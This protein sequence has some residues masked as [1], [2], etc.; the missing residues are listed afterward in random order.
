MRRATVVMAVALFVPVLLLGLG[1]SGQ[2]A[3]PPMTPKKPVTTEYQGVKVTDNYQWL[4]N[5][6]DPAVQKWISEENQYSRTFLDRIPERKDIYSYLEKIYGKESKD[7][8]SLQYQGGMIFAKKSQPPLEQPLLV[9]LASADDTTAERV[10]LDVNKL[11]T[12]GHTA[13]DFYTPSLDGKMIAVSLSEGGSEEGTVYVYDVATGQATSDTVPR[14]NGPTAGG[15]VAWNA[16]GTGFYYTHYPRFGERPEEDLSFYQQV[17]FH[18]LGTPSDSDSYVIG[19]EFPRIAEI[20]LE[21]S[22]DGKYILAVVANGDGGEY[23]HYLLSPNGK[24]TQITQFDDKVTTAMFGPDQ[25]LY[26]MSLDQAPHGKIIRVPLSRPQLISATVVVPTGEPVIK[27]FV[28]ARHVVYVA[29]LLG[30]PMQ[31]RVFDH[32]GNM[33]GN[34]KIE[35]VS[36]VSKMLSIGDDKILFNNT[37]YTVPPAWFEYEPD[38]KEPIRTQLFQTSPADFSNV[39]VVREFATAED[40]TKIPM[41]ILQP[42]GTRRDGENPTVLYGYGAYG[43]SE[44]PYFDPATSVWL[45]NGGVYV[46]ANIRGGGEYGEEWH[47]AGNLANKQTTFSDFATVAEWLITARYTSRE[48]LAIEGGSAGGLLMGVV[49]TQHPDLIRAVVSYVGVYDALRSEFEPNGEFN[50]T[51]FGSVKNAE[52]FKALY[53]YSPYHHVVDSVPYPAVLMLTG[54][55]DQR[56]SPANSFKMT[57]RLQEATSSGDPILLRTSYNAGHG[58]GSSLSQKINQESDV[59][60]FLFDELGLRYRPM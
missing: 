34:V 25:A 4:E 38:F 39:E 1:C 24:W 18:K 13:I 8:Y 44:T 53:A 49:L 16:D 31:V 56:V 23:S 7:Y 12:T 41:S 36:S 28:P 40:G 55:N 50:I 14:V 30:G 26:M 5:I 42:K 46:Y 57:A 59:W 19:K 60:A 11:D 22:P 6:N 58:I 33:K 32:D 17:Y 52:Q 48:K 45:D 3:K 37:S 35:T 9:T 2:S 51:E 27:S 15:S 54:V 20:E 29:D 47:L 21:T 10:V 43:I